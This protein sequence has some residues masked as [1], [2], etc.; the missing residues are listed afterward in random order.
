MQVMHSAAVVSSDLDVLLQ[1][2]HSTAL[3]AL[4]LSAAFGT[5]RAWAADRTAARSSYRKAKQ[6]LIRLKD[7]QVLAAWHAAAVQQGA[8]AAALVVLQQRAQVRTLA[9]A[10]RG[11]LVMRCGWQVQQAKAALAVLWNARVMCARVLVVW[12]GVARRAAAIKAAVDGRAGGGD[13][14]AAPTSFRQCS[15]S[16]SAAL[17]QQQAWKVS[18]QEAVV[19]AMQRHEDA[20]AAADAAVSDFDSQMP[21]AQAAVAVLLLQQRQQREV[22]AAEQVQQLQ[23]QMEEQAVLLAADDGHNLPLSA[24][25]LTVGVSSESSSS[26]WLS[27]CA[28][29]HHVGQEPEQAA[30]MATAMAAAMTAEAAAAAADRQHAGGEG[31]LPKQPAALVSCHPEPSCQQQQQQHSGGSSNS[32]SDHATSAAA[33][34]N[35]A[36]WYTSE[37]SQQQ[38]QQQQHGPHEQLQQMA[39]HASSCKLDPAAAV[40]THRSFSIASSQEVHT[41]ASPGRDAW[42]IALAE[43]PATGTP[44]TLKQE[45]A[46]GPA[47]AAAAAGG[48]RATNSADWQHTQQ[49]GVEA[50]A[51]SR[52]G[53]SS[54]SGGQRTQE[55]GPAAAAAAAHGQRAST[56]HCSADGQH[57]Q[58]AGVGALAAGRNGAS[59]SSGGQHTQ[60]AGLA[61]AAAA[62]AGGQR[63][64]SSTDGQRTQ[65]AAAQPLL[66][67]IAKRQQQHSSAGGSSRTGH[68]QPQA[69][70]ATAT[71][72]AAAAAAAEAVAYGT[73][74]AGH[75]AAAATPCGT[76][77]TEGVSIIVEGAERSW[78]LSLEPLHVDAVASIS[79]RQSF[80][81]VDGIQ[82]GPAAAAAAGGVSNTAG[83]RTA[84][85]TKQFADKGAVA[86]PGVPAAAT[87]MA[88]A[89]GNFGAAAHTRSSSSS[90]PTDSM[91]SSDFQASL[92]VEGRLLAV[93]SS[94]RRASDAVDQ[95][96]CS[97][98]CSRV[99]QGLRLHAEQQQQQ[100]Q[101]ATLT[102]Q[103]AVQRRTVRVWVAEVQQLR[104]SRTAAVLR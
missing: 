10:F 13:G 74:Q 82:L 8:A 60:Q 7:S 2:Q 61:A 66:L 4:L 25:Q 51:A 14:A 67:S 31:M 20:S 21:S 40:G 101:V 37:V 72:S 68:L 47:A 71:A 69:A 62:A 85:G 16:F 42:D 38:Q 59:S 26:S 78:S 1:Q 93:N 54:S 17:Q 36:A 63:A 81:Q 53:A 18:M 89:C 80:S 94:R 65:Q 35:V 34:R 91:F 98:L 103:L 24:S 88:E 58:Q 77:G 104:H 32:N 28:S 22:R 79:R 97:K 39:W 75:D 55:A 52:N 70:E 30:A 19:A 76:E 73:Q 11:W 90:S 92:K 87:A 96:A 102:W 27:V 43:L 83:S 3:P 6:G 12:A 86:A 9:K 44:E 84:G 64:S 41:L 49:A 100:S 99:L 45:A 33:A 23:R 15:S 48:Q 56:G 95:F 46:A 29:S 57:T 50:L 5:W